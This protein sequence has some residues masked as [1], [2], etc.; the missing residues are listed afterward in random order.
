MRQRVGLADSWRRLRRNPLGVAGL[1]VIVVLFFVSL[2]APL[3]ANSKPIAMQ[4]DG[5]W[6]FPALFRYKELPP[7]TDYRKLKLESAVWPLI[8][9]DYS[10]QD[11]DLFDN[12]ARPSATHLLG[13][14]PIGRDLLA[15]IIHGT[16]VSLKVGFVSVGISLAIGILLGALAGYY[17]GWVDIAISRLIE[18]MQCFPTF[19]LILT[20][21]VVIGLTTWTSLARMVR[22]EFLSLRDR[23]FVLAA[24][25]L[26]ASD[27]RIIF[28]HV[29]PNALAPVFV[30]AT[31]GVANAILLESTLSYLGLGVQPP[32]PSW[33]GLISEGQQYIRS[34]WWLSIFPGS[35]ILS[36]VLAYN[37][38]GESLRDALDPRMR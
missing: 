28:R 27:A 21:I 17:G 2:T 32:D 8:R 22:G 24:R 19:F 16:G 37:L 14:D 11:E 34:C 3:L 33:G 9:W 6:F 5:R 18:V 23:E 38:F 13:T 12:P 26:G 35:M 20:V 25:I 30:S 29:L 7:T 1:V 4:K 36:T 31:L 15:R 10:E